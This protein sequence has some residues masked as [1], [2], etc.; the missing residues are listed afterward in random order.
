MRRTPGRFALALLCTACGNYPETPPERLILESIPPEIFSDTGQTLRMSV[1]LSGTFGGVYT[2]DSVRWVSDDTTKVVI[3]KAG[4]LRT[5]K[6][7][8]RVLIHV[9]AYTHGSSASVDIP[10]SISATGSAL[11]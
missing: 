2:P 11:P 3:S 5:I 8:P 9:S 1:K 7:T 10:V 6:S 4:I